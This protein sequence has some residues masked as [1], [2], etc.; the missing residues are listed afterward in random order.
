M[1]NSL[2]TI[3]GTFFKL[4]GASVTHGQ[5]PDH[6][7]QLGQ[8]FPIHQ[9][10]LSFL[11]GK[12]GSPEVADWFNK[13]IHPNQTTFNHMA[14]TLNFAFQGNL[15]LTLSGGMIGDIPRTYVFE[16]VFLAQGDIGGGNNWWFG[17][18][19]CSFIGNHRVECKGYFH[20]NRTDEVN[21][22]FKRGG[23]NADTIE[24]EM[25]R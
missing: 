14:L 17:G 10:E 24:L 25:N 12:K 16:E 11:V 22:I 3:S 4:C 19:N 1:V 9:G 8:K 23:N 7:N 6:R 13:Q 20:N 15:C 5:D 18:K 21:A 2:Y